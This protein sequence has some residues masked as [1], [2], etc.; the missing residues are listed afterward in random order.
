L[1]DPPALGQKNEAFGEIR[2]LDHLN[3]SLQAVLNRRDE[4]G[5]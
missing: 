2:T 5:L 3:Q 1:L 4:A